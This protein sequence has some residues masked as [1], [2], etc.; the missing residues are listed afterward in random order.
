MKKTRAVLI[1]FLILSVLLAGACTSNDPAEVYSEMTA[2]YREALQKKGVKLSYDCSL[3]ISDGSRA[4]A[5][6]LNGDVAVKE[7]GEDHALALEQRGDIRIDLSVGTS[8]TVQTKAYY[9]EGALYSEL[10]DT[11]YT[12]K[13]DADAALAQLGPVCAPVIGL[14]TDDFKELTLKDNEDKTRTVSVMISA[15]SVGKIPGL[16][17][18]WRRIANLG[19]QEGTVTFQDV[20]GNFVIRDE[21]PVRES[22]TIIGTIRTADRTFSITEEL[23][24]A[25]AAE[26]AVDVGQPAV[27]Q[28]VS[29]D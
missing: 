1:V 20:R 22:L 29:L 27:R 12:K 13:M 2:K 16:A 28:Y 10:N 18:S 6:S 26:D 21:M 4:T 3:K 17:E 8:A 23:V 19:E 15:G 5:Y 9:H 11:R 25:I 24:L 14:D 7:G